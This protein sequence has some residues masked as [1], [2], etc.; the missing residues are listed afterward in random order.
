MAGLTDGDPN[1]LR[2]TAAERQRITDSINRL[3]SEIRKIPNI[4]Q[5]QLDLILRKLDEMNKA[6]ER[7]GRKDWINY[8]IGTLTSIGISAAFAP[9]AMRAVFH[10]VSAA[11]TWFFNNPLVLL[12]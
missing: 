3:Q 7:L 10:S 8:V 9:D 11:F 12:P 5:E 1:N 2:F 4:S 6:S